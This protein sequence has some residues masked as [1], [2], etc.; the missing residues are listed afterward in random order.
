M[1]IVA[2]SDTHDKHREIENIPNGDV[3]VFAGDMTKTGRVMEVVDFANWLER[4]PHKYKIVVA[5]NHDFCFDGNMKEDAVSELEDRGIIYLEDDYITVQDRLFYGSPRSSTFDDYV[6]RAEN[7]KWDIDE[8]VDVLITHGPPKNCMDY[9]KGYGNVGCEKLE[10]AKEKLDLDAH[11]FGHIH[12]VNGR[13]DS[14]FNVSI[15]DED[16]KVS[17]APMVIELE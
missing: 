6:F 15:L 8:D 11:I 13:V 9:S 4:L 16:Y 2:L 1:K 3:L 14:N 5:G 7:Y 10:E 12:E 17:N